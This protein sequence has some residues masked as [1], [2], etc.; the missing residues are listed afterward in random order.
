MASRN[1]RGSNEI[2]FST[3]SPKPSR[4]DIYCRAPRFPFSIHLPPLDDRSE[5]LLARFFFEIWKGVSRCIDWRSFFFFFL[6]DWKRIRIENDFSFLIN[7]F[8]QWVVWKIGFLRKE[9]YYFIFFKARLLRFKKF[10][11][12][13]FFTFHLD[14]LF[15][16]R[17]DARYSFER[18]WRETRFIELF[19]RI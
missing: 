2:A 14:E 4:P 13:Y 19:S 5:F 17:I 6:V 16:D 3:A 7:S 11:L 8:F 9:F 12:K 18:R 10:S 1:W 15:I